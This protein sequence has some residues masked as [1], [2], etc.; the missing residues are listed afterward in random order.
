MLYSFEFGEVIKAWPALVAGAASTVWLSAVSIV[1]G[2]VVAILGATAKTLGGRVIRF[3]IDCYIEVIRNTPFLVQV[4][5]IFF[6]LPSLGLRMSP[7]TAA[8]TAMV[9][10]FAAYAIEIIRAGIESIPKGQIDAGKALGLRPLKIFLLVVFKPA[11]QAIYPALTSQMILLML[12]SSICSA[13]AATELTAIAGDIQSRTFR[14]FE[15]YSVVT[16]MY[17]ALSVLFWGLFAGM[18]ALLF[19]ASSRGAV[20]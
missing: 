3:I 4:F 13:I 14:S 11:L 8:I 6:G 19:K 2:T 10:N 20:K 12:N 1:L 18:H 16:A 17:F 5:V 7:N 15:V 9:L